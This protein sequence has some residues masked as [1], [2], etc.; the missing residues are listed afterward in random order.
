MS[1]AY[2]GEAKTDARD[3]YVITQKQCGCG[4]TSP[5]GRPATLVAELRLLVT[6]APTWSLTGFG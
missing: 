2:A 6:T 5:R 3:A 4:V 1:T